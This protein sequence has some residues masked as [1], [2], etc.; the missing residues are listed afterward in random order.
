[1]DR[2]DFRIQEPSPFW[3]GWY[4]HKFRGP[5][6]RY[7]IGVCI[8]TGWICWVKGPFPCGAWSDL[9]IFNNFLKNKLIPDE[10]VECDNGYGGIRCDTPGKFAPTREQKQIKKDVR[11]RHETINR[12]FKQF[13]CLKQVWRHKLED[14]RKVFG[15]VATITQISIENGE[16][17]YQIHNY[18]TVND[19]RFMYS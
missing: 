5:G 7:E 4:S 19:L 1:M 11:A 14:H 3:N 18:H 10:R 9:K 13:G 2:T 8:Q 16:H 17:P 6:V 15:A 12:K